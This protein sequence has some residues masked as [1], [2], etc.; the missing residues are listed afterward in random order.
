LEE[1]RK[2]FQSRAGTQG[3]QG[4]QG[5]QGGPGPAQGQ[6]Q[7]MDPAELR[8]QML[9]AFVKNMQDYRKGLK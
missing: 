9:D 2:Q 3:T 6:R 1:M 5:A 7:Q 4:A 8:T